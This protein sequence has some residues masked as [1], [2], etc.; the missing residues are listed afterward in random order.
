VRAAADAMVSTG[1]IDHGWMYV[2]IDDCWEIKPGSKDPKTSGTARDEN[3]MI[4]T[5]GKFPDMKRLADYVH[6]KGLKIGLYSSPG[7]LTCGGY[8]ASYQHEDDDAKAYAAWGFD[9]LKYDWC[10][11]GGIAPKKPSLAEMKKPY[12]VMRASLDIVDR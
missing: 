4:N 8:T 10:S 2:N 1:L 9:Y 5:N 6:S 7:P 11:Y 12:E 3:G